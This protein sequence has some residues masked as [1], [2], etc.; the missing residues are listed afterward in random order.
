MNE[1][2]HQVATAGP[3]T[4][5]GTSIVARNFDSN[6]PK[7]IPKSQKEPRNFIQHTFYE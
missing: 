2:Y 6:L 1:A 4:L 7:A 5:N 3:T